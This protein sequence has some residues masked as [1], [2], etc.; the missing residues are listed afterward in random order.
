MFIICYNCNSADDN[1]KR[2]CKHC[3]EDEDIVIDNDWNDN[4]TRYHGV[5][6]I[7]MITNVQYA[8]YGRMSCI[9]FIT[10]DNGMEIIGTCSDGR[11]HEAAYRSAVK[12]IKKYIYYR[13]QKAKLEDKYGKRSEKM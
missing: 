3:G 11:G 4:P 13:E 2:I 9:C 6:I 1:Q 5:N 7:P 10:L 8:D 12:R